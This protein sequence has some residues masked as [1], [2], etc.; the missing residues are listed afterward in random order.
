MRILKG[1]GVCGGVT[2]GKLYIFKKSEKSV[3]RTHI[4]N[5][6]AELERFEA[7]RAKAMEQLGALYDKA[8]AEVGEANAMIFEIHQMMLDDEDYINSVKSII[9]EQ[10][11]NAETAVAV[12][13]DN[14]AEMFA[15]MDDSYMQARAA[16][17]KDISERIIN[18]LSG[19]D[20]AGIDANEPVIIAAENLAPSETVQM[21][22]SKIL[23]FVTEQGSSNSHTSILARTMNIPA[24]VC[25]K[26]LMNSEYHMKDAIV[27][28]SE[29]VIYIEPDDAVIAEMTAKRMNEEKQRAILNE[30]KNVKPVTKDGQEILIYANIGSPEDLPLVYSNGGQGVGLFRS[31]FL[32]L[33]S[34][35]YPTEDEQFA[36]Y[37][38]SVEKMAGKR[39]VIRTLDIGADKQVDYF[40]MP[41]EENPAMGVRAIRICLNRPDIFRTQLRA[42]LRASAYGKLSIMF[43][44][45]TSV[46]EV[47]RIK[48]IVKNVKTELRTEGIGFDENIELGI[49]IETPSA[50]IISDLLAKEVDFFSIGTNDLTQYTMAIDRQNPEAEKFCDRHHTSILRLIK[51]VTDN[52]HNN[53]IWV[54]ICGELGADMELTEFFLSIGVDELSVSP[55]RILPLKNKVLKTDV[56]R[57]RRECFEKYLKY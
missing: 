53:G 31:E 6:D 21:D 10:T 28:G 8:L 41:K 25:V 51:T 22:K 49:M 57:V 19:T 36:A 45:I 39:V 11:L 15:S 5:V 7:A 29:G 18:I 13:A 55:G 30:L 1:G 33:E 48:E 9:A 44:M 52:A 12:T 42:L 16:D 50:A 4:E 20:E 2:F 14:F 38:K 32:Y 24:V 56:G 27:D 43:P 54:G 34:D 35:H 47:R 46:D 23:A 37:K 26:D 40:D 3:K 17:V